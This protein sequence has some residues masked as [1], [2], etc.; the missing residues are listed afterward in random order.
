[1]TAETSHLIKLIHEPHVFLETEVLVG[2]VNHEVFVLR[3]GQWLEIIGK[4]ILKKNGICCMKTIA[5]K[6]AKWRREYGAG[7]EEGSH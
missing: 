7:P 6:M 2:K 1:M 4:K 3:C 5:F